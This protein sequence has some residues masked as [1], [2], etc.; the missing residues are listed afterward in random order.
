MKKTLVPVLLVLSLGIGSYFLFFYESSP[1]ETKPGTEENSKERYNQRAREDSSGYEAR[2]R[3]ERQAKESRE[4][5]EPSKY[6]EL[7]FD[8]RNNLL[9]ESVLEGKVKNRAELS[10]FRDIT[11]RIIFFDKKTNV[12]D[13]TSQVINETLA[14]GQDHSFKYKIKSPKGTKAADMKVAE[15]KI[16]GQ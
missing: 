14:P 6:L 5:E 7:N 11:L 1:A 12:L 4:S 10:S 9:G 15:A 2:L 16:S 13:S 8:Y 3:M